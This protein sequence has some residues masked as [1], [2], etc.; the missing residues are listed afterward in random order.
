MFDTPDQIKKM[1]DRI[2]VRAVQTHTMPQ[3]NKTGMTEAE[4]QLIG[5]WINQGASLQ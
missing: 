1:A 4:R 5:D 3:A 2:L